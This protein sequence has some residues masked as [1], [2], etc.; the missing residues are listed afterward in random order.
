VEVTHGKLRLVR[1]RDEAATTK[2]ARATTLVTEAKAIREECKKEFGD[3]HKARKAVDKAEWVEAAQW[4]ERVLNVDMATFTRELAKASKGMDP[5]A[6]EAWKKERELKAREEALTAKETKTATEKTEQERTAKA[7]KTIGIKVA[8]HDALKLKDG[9]KQVLTL[10][11]ANFNEKT[12]ELGMGY[13]QAADLVLAEFDAQALALGYT[14]P[15][16]APKPEEK[17][18]KKP[19]PAPGKKPFEA[20]A[21][22]TTP[23]PG[24]R[25]GSSLEE[26][27]AKADRAYG[28]SKVL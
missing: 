2:E 26:R 3:P 9:A 1:E 28:R 19:D 22:A 8:G 7:T 6:L 18:E 24:K 21:G 20:P 12:G 16:A 15:G 11:E 10:L 17:P 5:K 4:I 13:K 14:K 25:R 27:Q 23:E